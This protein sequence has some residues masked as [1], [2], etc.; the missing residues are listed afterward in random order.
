[1]SST[2]KLAGVMTKLI[3]LQSTT[4]TCKVAVVF[5]VW[6][7]SLARVSV[8]VEVPVANDEDTTTFVPLI[9]AIAESEV[10][11]YGPHS[12][13]F[14]SVVHVADVTEVFFSTFTLEAESATQ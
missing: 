9:V 3:G 11:V 1:M 2:A 10:T 12:E 14:V 6:S 13:S 5:I 8:T 4:V 7:L